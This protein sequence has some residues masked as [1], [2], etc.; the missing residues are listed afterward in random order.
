M[1]NKSTFEELKHRYSNGGMSMKLVY[2]NILIFIFI[3]ILLVFGRLFSEASLLRINEFVHTIFSLPVSLN[4]FVYSPWTLFTSIFAH[5]SIIH[6]L[7]NMLFLYFAGQFAENFLSSKKILQLYILGGIS[8]GIIEIIAHLIFPTLSS[9]STIIG[10]SGSIMAIFMF[11]A[12][13]KPQTKLSLF[14]LFEIQIIYL[15]LIYL[16]YDIISI[17]LNDGTAHFAHIGGFMIGYIVGKSQDNTSNILSIFDKTQHLL[18]PIY[19]LLKRKETKLYVK[20]GG[21]PL[22]DEQYNELKIRNQKKTDEILD[23]I[24]KSGY[25]TLTKTEKEFLFKQ[26]KNG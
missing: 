3:S 13:Y 20:P 2:I 22:T 17:G 6:L 11:S 21:R 5:Y 7:F 18:S 23:K 25:E 24:S 26:S 1:R 8:G 14:G 15:A 19:R 16:L 4:E 10:A 12:T 9:N